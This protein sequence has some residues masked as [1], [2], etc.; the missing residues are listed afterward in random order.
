M[1]EIKFR[2][3]RIYSGIWICGDLIHQRIWSESINSFM[4]REYDWGFDNYIE[5]EIDANTIGQFTGLYDKNGVEIYEGDI[6]SC[7]SGEC[8]FGVWEYSEIIK[9][10]DIRD[11]NELTMF[12]WE[13]I[14]VIGNL[15]DNPE[16]L[17]IDE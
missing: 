12:F 15:H 7:W 5:C 14:E 8:F 11:M 2:G 3:K 13:G 10:L 9:I 16:L 1:R 4:I 17:G 6:V